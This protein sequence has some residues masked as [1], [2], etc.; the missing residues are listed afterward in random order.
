MKAILVDDE[1]DGIRTLQKL[2]ERHCP[3]VHIVGTAVN[4]DSAGELIGRLQPDVVFLDIQMP[5]KTGIELL[6]EMGKPDF[7]VVFV[8]AYNEYMLQA[9]QFSAADY[10]LKPVDEDRL[11]EAVARVT[12]R[13]SEGEKDEQ[14]SAL[15][16]N[17][18]N[19]GQPGNM[20]LCLPTFK[21]FT[22]VKLGEIIYCEAE[23]SYTIFHLVDGKTVT[24]SKPLLDYDNLLK[25]TT[26]LRVHKSYLINLLHIKEYIRGEGGQVIMSDGA[27]IEISRRRKDEFLV[28]VKDVFKY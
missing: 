27:E 5:G 6:T 25:G 8:T 2:L 7:E 28:L 19:A 16:H 23:R 26:F 3:Q 12:K 14:S 1:A 21:G 11:V 18:F 17:L 13:L 20:R 4:A 24:V 10:I 15:L 22:V 9:L